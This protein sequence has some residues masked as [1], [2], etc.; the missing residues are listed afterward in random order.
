LLK[1]TNF[2]LAQNIAFVIINAEI[3]FQVGVAEPESQG[4]A[5]FAVVGASIKATKQNVVAAE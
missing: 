2:R 5:S 3:I 1:L 4:A